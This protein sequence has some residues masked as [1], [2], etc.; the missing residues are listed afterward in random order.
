VELILQNSDSIDFI[1]PIYK[2]AKNYGKLFRS[3][4]AD[5]KVPLNVIRKDPYIF[6]ANVRGC[7]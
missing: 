5:E 1:I 3:Y 4:A 2:L 6:M 7:F